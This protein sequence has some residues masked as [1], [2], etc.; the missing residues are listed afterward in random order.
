MM[1][2][3]YVTPTTLLQVASSTGSYCQ[4]LLT[5]I[6]LLYYMDVYLLVIAMLRNTTVERKIQT[7]LFEWHQP[8]WRRVLGKIH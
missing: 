6:H 2:I 1:K 3:A 8:L 7:N 4:S 5:L